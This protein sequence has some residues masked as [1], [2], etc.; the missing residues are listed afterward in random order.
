MLHQTTDSIYVEDQSTAATLRDR[1]PAPATYPRCPGRTQD[2]PIET[3]TDDVHL[4]APHTAFTI[5]P[6]EDGSQSPLRVVLDSGNESIIAYC[7]TDDRYL[8]YDYH[9]FTKLLARGEITFIPESAPEH[10]P[11]TKQIDCDAWNEFT[12]ILDSVLGNIDTAGYY[13]IEQL[14]ALRDELTLDADT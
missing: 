4:I 3:Q 8:S 7:L 9:A 12:T 11:E 14:D 2:I 6:I 10:P 13:D 5:G 1:L